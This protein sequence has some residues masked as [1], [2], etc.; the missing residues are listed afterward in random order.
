MVKYFHQSW[1]L[2]C[3]YKSVNLTEYVIVPDEGVFIQDIRYER[4]LFDYNRE[5]FT[6]KVNL[7]RLD[8]ETDTRQDWE[9][10]LISASEVDR[11]ILWDDRKKS[12]NK[13]YSGYLQATRQAYIWHLQQAQISC[14]LYY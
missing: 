6:R 14:Q 13:I 12:E 7:S 9:H 5:K 10:F 1:L 3:P 8:E 2:D 4:N 11:L